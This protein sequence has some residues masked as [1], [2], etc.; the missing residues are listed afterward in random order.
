[1]LHLLLEHPVSSIHEIMPHPG[2]NDKHDHATGEN[3]DSGMNVGI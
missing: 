2:E 1:M 3:E